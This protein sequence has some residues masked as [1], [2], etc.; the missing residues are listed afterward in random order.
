MSRST[1][2]EQSEDADSSGGT[3]TI[4]MSRSK[5]GWLPERTLPFRIPIRPERINLAPGP[6][7]R[8]ASFELSFDNFHIVLQ[9]SPDL[10]RQTTSSAWRSKTEPR[11]LGEING[12]SPVVPRQ[13]RKS[14]ANPDN[15]ER[16]RQAC[17]EGDDNRQAECGKQIYLG[18]HIVYGHAACST[19]RKVKKPSPG[20]CGDG[21]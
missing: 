15:R 8:R 19:A 13:A 17:G 7:Q 4:S 9:R 14:G 16:H 6:G 12:R 20:R 11:R 5:D 18:A 21:L 2:F 3:E 10:T 1:T